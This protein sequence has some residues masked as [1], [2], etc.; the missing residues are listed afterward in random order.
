MN[1]ELEVAA[2]QGSSHNTKNPYTTHNTT[3]N[4]TSFS[5]FGVSYSE[6]LRPNKGQRR[7]GTFHR[8]AGAQLAV[9]GYL[10]Y[11]AQRLVSPD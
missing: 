2:G 3:T 4:N 5:K 9:E 7:R 10:I 1:V 8:C 11:K 6:C